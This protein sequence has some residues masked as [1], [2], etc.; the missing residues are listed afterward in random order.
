MAPLDRASSTG[1]LPGPAAGRRDAPLP[2][3]KPAS[4]GRLFGY[5][6]LVS[7]EYVFLWYMQAKFN[8]LRAKEQGH[9]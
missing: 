1:G 7:M 9:D 5:P 3:P 2:P 6:N 4:R 8:K